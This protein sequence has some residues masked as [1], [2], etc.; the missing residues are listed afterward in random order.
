MSRGGAA[1]G[2]GWCQPPPHTSG[3][4][5]VRGRLLPPAGAN[6]KGSGN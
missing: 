1:K 2:S 5:L 6:E 3:E 4:L